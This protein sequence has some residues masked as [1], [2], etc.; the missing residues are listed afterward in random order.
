MFHLILQ[1]ASE[2]LA[3]KTLEVRQALASIWLVLLAPVE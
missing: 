2:W 1:D 3:E